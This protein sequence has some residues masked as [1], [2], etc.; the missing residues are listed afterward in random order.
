LGEF[1]NE[2]RELKI[3]E[4]WDHFRESK[5][6]GVFCSQMRLRLRNFCLRQSC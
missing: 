2:Q 5:W 4:Y 3:W 1:A 6:L